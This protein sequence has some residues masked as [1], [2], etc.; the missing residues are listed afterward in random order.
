MYLSRRKRR[1]LNLRSDRTPSLKLLLIS[2][3]T[4][5]VVILTVAGLIL[6]PFLFF[7]Y[8]RQ[9]PSPDK[10]V[11]REGFSTVI[12]DREKRPLFDIYLQENRIPIDL[13]SVPQSLKQA[14]ISIED[15]DFYKHKGFDPKGI[16]RAIFKIITLQDIQGGSTLTQQ[17]VKNVLLSS[18]RTIPRKIKEFILAVQIESK[19]SKDEILQ[20]YLNEAPYGGTMWGIEAAAQG[21]F[22]KSAK[23]LDI[24]ESVI[25]AG[26]PQRP[27]YYSPF[28]VNEDAYIDRTKQVLR[29]IREDGYIQSSEELDLGR[30]LS[31]VKFASKGATFKAPH[32]VM[33][34]RKLLTEQFGERLVEAG[35]LKVTTTLDLNLQK[36]AEKIVKEELDKIK[37]LNVGNGAAVVINPQTGEILSYVGSYDYHADEEKLQGKF[38]VV[39]LG[40]RQ[41]GSALKPITYAVAFSKGYTPS[42]LIMD[43]ETH[44]PGG[45]Q[46]APDYIP[47]NYDGKSRGAVQL[48]FALGNSI[49]VPAVKIT[50][51]V[52]VRDILKQ[53]YEM[54]LTTLEPTYENVNRLGLSLTLGGGE[55]RLL[56]LTSAYGVFAASGQLYPPYAIEKVIDKDGKTLFERK[57]VSGK[58]VLSAEVAFLIS[59]ILLDSNARKEVFGPRSYLV[60]SGKTVSVKTGTTDDIKDNWTIGYT[61]S[62]V[63][64]VW[65]GNNDNSPMNS[66]LASGVTGAAPIWNRIISQTLGDKQDEI[67]TQPQ[68]VIALQIDAFGGGLPYK[69]SPT[70]S[71]YFIKGTEPTDIAPVYQKLKLS[72]AD[73]SKLAN[74]VEILTGNYEEK[75]FIVL[76]EK[77]PISEDRNRWQEGIDKWLESQE[78][79]K[80]HPPKDTS[81]TEENKVVV[82]I[83]KPQ[84]KQKID[85]EEIEVEARAF[86][87]KEIDKMELYVNDSRKTTVSD[88]KLKEKLK[89]DTGVYKIKIKALSKDGNSGEAEIIIGIKVSADEP[90]PPS[91]SPTSAPTSSPAPTP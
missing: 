80:Y 65:V 73:T 18:E 4:T 2:R 39:S 87:L 71:E 52:G 25:L 27:S 48:R 17:L 7:W 34:V 14:T 43:V 21:Y 53:A 74:T 57:K 64:G 89:L 79:P 45:R 1:L 50:A 5:L 84:D 85:Q 37:G 35:G 46:G 41:P 91:P 63:V 12:L 83:K 15:K 78:D 69:D 11:R 60:V 28:G 6:L 24:L 62:V 36:E 55:V 10:V 54:G 82:E 86:A 19:Y 22:G 9:L 20:M 23:D 13:P 67:I 70:R 61:P 77:D 26:F 90:L 58:R 8:S 33:Y 51:L 38:D 29:R 3:I 32:F 81:S 75:E 49:N 68:G 72:R 56:D 40:L 66:K 31:E 88:N 76:Q 44:F 16:I 59:H 42:S 30:R 47:K